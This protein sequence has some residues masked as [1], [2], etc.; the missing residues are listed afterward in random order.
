M[1]TNLA[2]FIKNS[3]AGRDAEE[4][5]RSCVHC[6]FCT[7]TCPTYQLLGDERDGPRGRI[8][9]IK[10]VLE[11][12]KASEKTQLHLDRCLTCRACETTCPSGVRYG[13]LLD[14]G[15]IVVERQ[16]RRPWLDRIQR[17]LL[18]AILPYP[19]RFAPLA[20]LGRFLRPLAPSVL[21][22]KI[23]AAT[24]APAWPQSSHPRKMLVL[25]GCV[26]PS[27]APSINAAAAQVF[28]RLGISL[29]RAEGAGCCGAL[30]YHLSAH[31]EGKGF[32]R[33]NI[34]AW[35][36]YLDNGVETIVMTASGCGLMV[37]EYGEVLKHDSVYA[38]K[39]ARIAAMT[40]DLVEVLAGEDLSTLEPDVSRKLAFHSPC[41]LQHGQ[42]LNGRVERLLSGL[43]FALMPVADPHLCCGSAG[44]Y[45][46][47]QPDISDR[48]LAKKVATL[49]AGH[50]NVIATANIG[51][52]THIQ[53]G[54]EVP[55]RH[56]IEL[57]DPRTAAEGY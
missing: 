30:S 23:P 21:R 49:E 33:R 3:P 42:K 51:C 46:L 25:E 43:G 12:E 9:L 27:L 40:K 16:V 53:S 29:V 15:R 4:I 1:Q 32:M 20:R 36:P 47:L 54:T 19:K 11:G 2:D 7:A 26:Q 45:S 48:L 38:D 31:E 35:L 10:Q 28:D 50:P 14:I 56:W 44:T 22:K 8:Y 37:K 24:R 18:R 6:G 13:R 5:L 52:L 41:T 34:D 39:A 57:L 17:G 55:V